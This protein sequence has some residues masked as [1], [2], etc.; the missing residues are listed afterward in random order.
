MARYKRGN[1]DQGEFISINFKDQF[2]EDS[3][4]TM[5]KEFIAKHTDIKKFDDYYKN[6]K[7]GRIGKHPQDIISAI[8]YGYLQGIR[9][10]R[11]VENLLR[12]HVGFMYVSNRLTLDHSK[13]CKFKIQFKDEIKNLFALIMFLLN[14][15]GEIDWD[16]VVGDGTKIKAYA[17]KS[18]TMNREKAEK[19]MKTY[20]KMAEKVI[21]RDIETDEKLNQGELEVEKYKREKKRI[22]RQKKIY[23]RTIEQ[24]ET[25]QKMIEDG[26]LKD[27]EKTVTGEEHYNLTDP[28]SSLTPGSDKSGFIQGYN[29]RMMVSNNDIILSCENDKL[30]EKY[31]AQPMIEKV[32]ELK[33]E[34]A[35]KQE[36]KY[37][38]DSGY[39]NMPNIVEMEEKG[40][41]CYI[42]IK[43]KDFGNGSQKRKYFEIIK[44]EN[45]EIKLKCIGGIISKGY[46]DKK[47]GKTPC[48]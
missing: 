44:N 31:G 5:L 4:E 8:L 20:R 15:I 45:G 39:Q 46:T 2:S 25:Y 35:V 11:K 34:L 43:D 1:L 13:L 28:N 14:N 37:L 6:D 38:M 9:S 10:S 24:I 17:S 41:D 47:R 36:S 18:R 22:E 21:Q 33:S 40:L 26:T 12:T 3:R 48:R 29:I 16:L 42:D 30:N 27:G 7:T 23:N 19:I 32:E